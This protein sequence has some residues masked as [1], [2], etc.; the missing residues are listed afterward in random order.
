MGGGRLSCITTASYKA[1]V[2]LFTSV[3]Y[4]DGGQMSDV[5]RESE[6]QMIS[7][8]KSPTTTAQFKVWCEHCSIRI[9]PNEEQTV[10]RGKAYHVRC[11]VR[12]S[13]IPKPKA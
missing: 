4:R 11:Y 1:F 12:A 3:E 6:K 9:A 10:V 2:T 5:M 13:A 7:V 8:V